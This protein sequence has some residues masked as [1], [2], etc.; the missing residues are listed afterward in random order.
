MLMLHLV[1]LVTEVTGPQFGSVVHL[2]ETDKQV[3]VRRV[4]VKQVDDLSVTSHRCAVMRTTAGSVRR[5]RWLGCR[6][7]ARTGSGAGRVAPS[8]A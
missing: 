5:G 3:E 6:G 2:A 7:P 1:P 4:E 8:A